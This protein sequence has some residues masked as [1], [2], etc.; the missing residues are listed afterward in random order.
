MKGDQVME[1][2]NKERYL[3]FIF[4]NNNPVYLKENA[5]LDIVKDYSYFEI[6]SNNQISF[7]ESLKKFINDNNH[8]QKKFIIIN[9]DNINLDNQRKLSY[10]V[11][12]KSYQTVSLPDSCKIIVTGSKDNIVKELFGLLVAIDV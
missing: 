2:R 5:I 7:I 10:M 4:E 1:N 3:H 8:V 9:T 12:D 11:K 6:N